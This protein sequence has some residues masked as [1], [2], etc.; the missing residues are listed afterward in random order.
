MSAEGTGRTRQ[1]LAAALGLAA[2]VAAVLVLG[3]PPSGQPLD[4][5]GVDPG[6]LRGLV[7]VLTALDVDVEVADTPPD[8][9]GTRVLVARDRLGADDR[10]ALLAWVEAGGTLVVADP[11]SLLHGLERVGSD[12][13]VGRSAR[14]P[15]CALLPEVREVRQGDWEGLEVPAGAEAC[16]PIG[17]GAGAWLVAQPRGAGRLV[18]LGSA[19]PLTNAL[20]DEADN[21]VLAASLLGPSPGDRLRIVP[22]TRRPGDVG[23][24]GLLALVA[25]RVWWLLGLLAL[26]LVLAVV[27]QA[28]RDGP[29]VR[30]QLPPVLPSAELARSLAG[31]LQ[32]SG[33]RQDAAD[34]LRRQAR[35]TVRHACGLP[36]GQAP[37]ALVGAVVDRG[38]LAPDDARL[39]LVPAPVPDD[40]A[41]LAV[42][43]AVHRLRAALARPTSRAPSSSPTP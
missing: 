31:L 39:A 36:T 15:A 35:R 24:D 28:R 3:P 27:W 22:P 30:E 17:D 32:R 8:E 5:D 11:T 26:A 10:E 4:P 6:G 25:D 23:D 43:T 2:L 1:L 41:L 13:L 9:A 42:A 37:E 34:R 12:Q 19:Q 16:F 29:V 40:G 33:G 7:E 21:A 20:L 38:L 18:A 14:A